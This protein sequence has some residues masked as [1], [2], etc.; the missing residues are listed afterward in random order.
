MLAEAATSGTSPSA[1][2]SSTASGTPFSRYGPHGSSGSVPLV[3]TGSRG[4]G[5]EQLARSG[6]GGDPCCDVHVDP[7]QLSPP[8]VS[9]P[10]CTPART[11]STRRPVVPGWRS[12]RDRRVGLVEDGHEPVAGVVG[13]GSAEPVDPHGP[14]LAQSGQRQRRAERPGRVAQSGQDPLRHALRARRHVRGPSRPGIGDPIPTGSMLAVHVPSGELGPCGWTPMDRPPSG[15]PGSPASGDGRGPG[16]RRGWGDR[17]VGRDPTLGGT[18][19]LS[20]GTA[21]H[22]CRSTRRRRPRPMVDACRA[23]A[24]RQHD[25]ER[26]AG[27]VIGPHAGGGRTACRDPRR[28]VVGRSRSDVALPPATPII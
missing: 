27:V 13:R 11:L 12:A 26:R 21:R 16:R 28:H 9:A 17:G 15:R 25:R 6:D 3:R 20:V 2:H 14:R 18:R 22:H 8:I 24:R 4:A 23:A 19:T 7:G 5:G 10:V 1:R